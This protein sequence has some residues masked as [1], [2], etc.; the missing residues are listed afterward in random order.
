MH[1]VKCKYLNSL[2]LTMIF[3]NILIS[4]TTTCLLEV[5]NDLEE[6]EMHYVPLK[7]FTSLRARRRNVCYMR[8]ADGITVIITLGLEDINCSNIQKNNNILIL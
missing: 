7:D 5:G 4:L 1:G 3:K 8:K 2:H 6:K